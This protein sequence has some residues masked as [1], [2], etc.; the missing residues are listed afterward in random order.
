MRE[1][2]IL[3]NTEMVR[4]ILA[5]QKKKTR[6][7][8]K[9]MPPENARLELL[10]DMK[11]AMDLSIEI[12]GPSDRRIYTPPY[13]PGDIL[14]VRETWGDFREE[15]PS[16]EGYWCVYKADYQDGAVTVPLPEKEQTDCAKE[17]DL[18][19]WHPSIH[20]PKEYARIWL[21][22]TDVQVEK[23][24]EI[25]D[26]GAREEGCGDPNVM[27][28]IGALTCEFAQLWDST[29]KPAETACKGWAANPW[30]WVTE[31]ERCE[32]PGR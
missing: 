15:D 28:Y 29:L 11:H 22:V 26:A 5:G 6:R 20:M 7:L 24:R 8:V 19:K 10:G 14:Y 16:G 18:P 1:L 30:V 21:R 12:P 3:F 25:T 23:L 27:Y 2:P 4:R 17:W 31:F 9:P 32:K 13:L